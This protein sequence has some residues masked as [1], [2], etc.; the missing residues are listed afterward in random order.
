MKW[1]LLIP[2]LLAST[3]VVGQRKMPAITFEAHSTNFANANRSYDD[4]NQYTDTLSDLAIIQALV[5]ILEENP[6]L[7]IALHGHVAMN[8]DTTL[9]VSRATA[10]KQ[11]LT[12]L[13]ID[14]GRIQIQGWG[15]RK[16]LIADDVI[17]SLTNAE[18]REAGNQR[19]RRV[20]VKV[21]GTTPEPKSSAP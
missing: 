18:E 13:G 4:N 11:R 15:H 7:I 3:L 5:Q 16:P 1:V 10:V 6:D 14:S 17:W 21:V 12:E 20:E 9:A 19:N 8:E 2:L